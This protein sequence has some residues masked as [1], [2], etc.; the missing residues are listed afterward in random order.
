MAVFTGTSGNDVFTA[1]AGSNRYEGLAGT[2]KIIFNF[3]LTDATITFSGTEV[4]VDTAT[5][6]TVLTGFQTYQFSDG[7]VEENDGNPLV[8]DLFYY[9]QNHDVWL[10][11]ADADA[12]Y[13]NYGWKEGRNPNPFFDTD[14]YLAQ[15]AD[16]KA[17]GMNPLEHFHTYGWKDGRIPSLNFD[18]AGY[19]AQNP[20]VA[21]T[22]MD[23][24]AHFLAYGA[25]EGRQP[26][27]VGA[28][29][30]LSAP[31][32]PPAPA[33]A[34]VNNSVAANG[35][36]ADYYRA[37][38]PD[39][40][41][42]GID[43]FTHFQQ[44]GWKEG[45][46]PNA[47]FDVTGYLNTYLDIKAAGINPLEHYHSYG[48]K[49]GRN[50]SPGFDTS[51][52][53]DANL[54]V[55]N[56]GLD[57]LWHFLKFGSG[58]GRVA[59]PEDL[60]D[61]SA[62]D[63]HVDNGA[64]VNTPVGLTAS[65]GNWANAAY[66][67]TDSAGGRFK[68]DATTGVVSVANNS[69]ITMS[70]T[71]E[72]TVQALV[73]GHTTTK[74]F[75]IIVGT[76]SNGDPVITSDG[77]GAT[78]TKSI[79]ENTTAVTT[80]VA[81]DDGP[82]TTYS[83]AG[84]ADAAKFT[85]NASTGAL[86]FVSAPNF[87]SPT[88]ADTNNSYVVTVRASDGTFFDE[89]TITV[90]VTDANDIAPVFTSA[91]SANVAENSTSV[92]TLTAVD[93]DTVGTVTFSIVGGADAGK[94]TIVGN[95]LRFIDAPNFEA[96]TDAG[97]NNVYDV[98]I[99]ASDGVNVTLQSIAVTVTD[100]NEFAVTVIQDTDLAPDNVSEDAPTGT[101]VG[102]TAFA[103]D[104][105]SAN[106]VITYSLDDD[107]G[108]FAID[109]SSGVVTV[110]SPL[111]FEAAQSHTIVV[112]ATS[113]DGS[114][115]TRSYIIAVTNV[116]DNTP[117]AVADTNAAVE[118]VIKSV[119][120]NV[121][122]NDNDADGDA[123]SV[124]TTGT[125]DGT[126]GQLSLAAD[127][128]YTYKLWTDVAGASQAQLDAVQALASGSTELELFN[129]T[130]SDGSGPTSTST[131][132]ITVHGLNDAPTIA[133]GQS[134]T[135]AED[136][137]TVGA[138]VADDVDTGAVLT[139]GIVG[140]NDAGLFA[141]DPSTGQITVVGALD[142]ETATSHTLAVTV[143]DDQGATKGTFVTIN[144]T[145]VDDVAPTIGL[146][147]LSAAENQTAVAVL[148]ATDP[149]SA[150]TSNAS[151]HSY[152]FATGAGDNDNG[153]FALAPDGTLT[154]ASAQN[155]EAP[156]D[157]DHDGVYQVR[158]K[159]TDGAG[160]AREQSITVTLTD[161]NDA[162]TLSVGSP[163]PALET[164]S[165]TQAGIAVAAANAAITDPDNKIS[166]LEIDIS[167][168]YQSTG[169]N[170]EHAQP[171]ALGSFALS[172]FGGSA[173]F[174]DHG[175]HG[176][177]TVTFP[178]PITA[179]QATLVLQQI[180]YVNQ[181]GD[182]S[183]AIAQDDTR[184]IA[185]R[186]Q[187]EGGAW[188][189][190]ETH[191]V[192]VAA[193]VIDGNGAGTFVGGSFADTINGGGGNDT[194][195]GGKGNDVII[196]GADTD[197]V[198]YATE[199]TTSEVSVA[200]T[201]GVVVNLSD[202]A[203]DLDSLDPIYNS[204]ANNDPTIAANSATD[205]Y[206]D[207][208]TLSGI[209]NVIG[210]KFDDVFIN[211]T[212]PSVA[213]V[214]QGGGTS[215]SVEDASG[216]VAGDTVVYAGTL[217]EWGI[218][219]APGSS[220]DFTVTK[221]T[222][223]GAGT[224]DTLYNIEHIVIGNTIID[225]TKSVYVYNDG[226]LVNTYDSVEDAVTAANGMTPSGAGLVVEAGHNGATSYNE[227]EISVTQA[228]TIR[229]VGTARPTVEG[230]FTVSGTLDGEFNV[231]HLEIDA[232]GH[233][234][235]VFVSA[236][237]T[238]YA[239]SVTLE[240]VS[241]ANA[242]V[243]GFAYIREGNGST[244]T[245][246]DT[247]GAIS[248]IDSVFSGNAT[249]NVG[250]GG[251][252]DIMLFGYNQDLTIDN[253]EIGSPGAWAQKAIQMRGT[254]TGSDAAGVG[255]YALG[256]DVS[257]TD[258]KITGAYATDA[259]A[260]YR[261]ASFASFTGSGNEIAIT[262]PSNANDNAT[263][264][265]WA[266][267]NFDSV[268]GMIDLSGFFAAASNMAAPDGVTTPVPGWI[269]Q[270]QGLAGG[271]TFTGTDGRDLLV[272][273]GGTNTLIGGGGDDTYYVGANDTV[274]EGSNAGTD[275]VFTTDSYTLSANVENLTLLD[276]GVSRTEAF[277]NFDLG[278]IANGENGWTYAGTSDQT[279]VDLG[280][281]HGKVLRMSSDPSTGAFGGPY[282]PP[283]TAA[284]GEPQ[285][286]AKFSG[287]VIRFDFKAVDPNG[288][289]SRMEVDFGTANGTDRNSFM[290]IESTATG[291]IRIAV[292]EPTTTANNW[293]V[294]NFAAFTGNR[295]LATDADPAAWHQIEL[296]VTYADGPNNDL[297]DIYLDGQYI[298]TSTT[299]ENLRDWAGGTHAANAEA[300][301]TNQVFFRNSSGGAP[302][303]GPGGEN[304]GFYFDNIS[305]G[306]YNSIGGTGNDLDN[307]IT[308]NSG[309][310]VLT[311]GGGNDT[312]IGGAGVDT[313]K[314]D[315]AYSN[316]AVTFTANAHGF[317]TGA[318]H[319]QES[320][321]AGVVAE[322]TDTLSG[323]ERLAFNGLTL[324]L[325]KKV[326]LFDGSNKLV[327]T[328]DSIQAAVDGASDG[329]TIR[330]AAGSYEESVTIDQNIA[331]LG[332]NDGDSASGARG[333]E[334]VIRGQVTVS[335]AHSATDKVVI[336]GVKIYNTSDNTTS[337]TGITV[338]SAADVEIK[339]SI[340]Y[341][342][343]PNAN[344]APG[345]ADRAI[346]LD[347]GATGTILIEDNRFTGGPLAQ[348]MYGTAAWTSAIWSDGR[349]TAATVSSNTFEW[350][351]TAINADDFN[352]T[353][354]VSGNTF[355]NAGSGIS[356]GG[357]AGGANVDVASIT[358]IHDNTFSNVG[359]DFNLQ[360][361]SAAGKDVGLDL[362]A[363]NNHAVNPAT[364]AMTVLGGGN[365]DTIKGSAGIDIIT[366]NGGAD[367]IDGGAGDDTIAG[368]GG[369]DTL[370]GGAG[371][372]TLYG[373]A[374]AGADSGKDTATY[375]DARANY[376]V[377]VTTGTDG[378][379][380]AF[381][382]VTETTV[383]GTDEG[384]D[385]LS[386]IER[387]DFAGT[388]NDLD[389]TQGVQVF[390]AGV[391]IATAA[392]ITDA[393]AKADA[394]DTVLVNG[395]AGF[396]ALTNE[397]VTISE[398][399]TLQGVTGT[400]VTV[401][402]I[403]VNGGVSGANLVIDNIDVAG[404]AANY[405]VQIEE[406]SVYD[407]VTF[408]NGNVT[409]GSY[410]AFL[411]GD[412][413]ETGGPTGVL[414]VTIENANFT[415]NV[416]T[417]SGGGGDAAI[418]FYRYNGNVTLT[419]VDVT[420]SGAFIE[421][422]IQIR[423]NATLAASGT[424][425]FND[426]SVTGAFAKVG[427][428]IRDYLAT[429]LAFGGADPALNI[430][431]TGGT[432]YTGLHVDG[433]GGNV[434]LSVAPG[435]SVTNNSANPGR[436]DIQVDGLGDGSQITGDGGSDV[437][438]G[439]GGADT[440]NGLGGND[441]IDGG[442]G[443]DTIDAGAG[444]DLIVQTAGQGGGSIE[445]GS[446]TVADTVLVRGTTGS[447]TITVV[448]DGTKITTVDGTTL[449]GIEIVNGTLDA[450][451]VGGALPSVAGGSDTLSYTG[452]S[453][454]VAVNLAAGTA[455]GFAANPAI[456]AGTA[457][458]GFENVTG[459]AGDDHFIGDAGANTLDGGAGDDTLRG[460]A[461][462]D[463][464]IG[465]A[466]TLGDTAIYD[467][468]RGNYTVAA[469]T[470]DGFVTAF[471]D[472]TETVVTGTDEGHDTLSGIEILQ[473]NG[474]TLNL[475]QK[476]QLFDGGGQLIGTFDVIQDAVTAASDGNTIRIKGG[477][478]NEDITV[479]GKA[480]TIDGVET[481]GVNDVT[482]N[483]MITVTG[484]L[485]GAFAVT[486][487][488]I[489]AAGKNYG[490]NVTANST[491]GGS[492]T[493]DDVSISGAAVNGFAYVRAG[494]GTAPTLTDTVGA[495]TISNSAFSQ[496]G[497]TDNGTGDILLF[498]YNGALT[499]DTVVINSTT[500]GRAIQ[501]RGL[502]DGGDVAGV[503]PYDAAGALVL[504]D[505]TIS[506]TY[507]RDAIAFYNIANFVTSTV[508]NVNMT[509]TSAAWGLFNA[510][511][512]GGTLDLSGV[513]G[514]NLH[515]SG[516]E[517]N[518][519]GL[520]Q[521]DTL[522]GTA[523][524]DVI[525]GRGGAD[526][527][528]AGAGNDTIVWNGGVGND[529]IDGGT[530]A[531][532]DTL[533]IAS[534][535]SNITLD[536]DGTGNADEFTV[537]DGVGTATVKE[538][539]EV[540]VTLSS[541][542]TLTVTGDF[543]GTGVNTSTIT[544]TGAGGNE[545]VDASG[546]TGAGPGSPVGI[547]FTGGGGDDTFISGIGNDT[548][549]GGTGS[550]TAV[551]Q[552]AYSGN[553]T[554]DG[555]TATVT[556]ARGTD[557]YDGV[558]KIQFSGGKTV[559][560]VSQD[561]GSEYTE[562]AQLFDG[563]AANGEVAAGDVVLVAGGTYAGGFIVD[564]AD[565]TIKATEANVVIQSAS[566]VA[567]NAATMMQSGGY[568]GVFGNGITVKA[569]GITLDGI[570][571]SSYSHGIVM[572]APSGLDSV[573]NDL[574]LNGVTVED[575]WFGVFKDE[576]VGVEDLT[577]NGGLIAQGT[578]GVYFAGHDPAA[579]DATNVTIDGTH[580]ADIN[581]KGIYAETLQ[582]A[583]LFDH[584]DMDNV[585]Q[586]GRDGTW[587][588]PVSFANGNGAV[589]AG[590][591]I[592]LK[593]EAFTGSITIQNF[594]FDNVGS[595]TG[596]DPL[597]H[598]N[599]AAISIKV[600]DDGSYFAD[601]ASFTGP[602]VIQN[603]TID[604]TSTGIRVGEPVPDPALKADPDY[605]TGPSVTVTNV[606]INGERENARHDDIDNVTSAGILTYNGT[607]DADDIDVAP[608]SLSTVILNGLGGNDALSGGGGNDQLA[609]GADNDTLDG[610]AGIDT[611][612]YTQA[613]DASM[614]KT[615]GGGWQVAA[616]GAEGTDTLSDIEIVD[617]AGAGKFLLVG[618]GGYASI[619]AAYAAASDGDTI[620]LAG[621]SYAGN[622]T[623]EKAISIVGANYG[624]AADGTRGLESEITG[625]L[626][627][628]K[629]GVTIDGIKI[630][631]G[632][633]VGGT[634]A[635]IYVE[636]DNVTITNTVFVGDGTSGMAG[637]VTPYGADV[638][639]LTLSN[640]S[641]AGW[642]WATYFNP[643]TDFEV[644]GN[645]FHDT[646]LI[647]DDFADTSTIANNVFDGAGAGIGYG[648]FDSVDDLG[649]VADGTNTYSNGSNN[650]IYLYGDG[651]A[652]GQTVYGTQF[653]DYVTDQW[654]YV[655]NSGDDDYVVGRDGNDYFDMTAG[656]DTM[657]GGAG[658]DVAIGGAGTDKAV[659]TGAIAVSNISLVADADSVTAG[660]Q[661]G[662]Q[663]DAT[664]SG[665]GT[666]G[667]IDVEIVEYGGGAGRYL[668][669]GQGG[670]TT[671]QDAV[672]AANDGDTILI[673]PGTW[674][675][676]GNTNIT[677][678]KAVT[679]IGMGATRGD[680][681][682]DATGAA[683]GFTID[684]AADKDGKTVAFKN[685]TVDNAGNS[686]IQASDKQV[687]GTLSLDNVAITDSGYN[688]LYVAGR[689]AS[690]AYAQAG[691]QSVVIA[692][693][694]FANNAQTSNNAANIMFFE[695]DGNAALTNVA[696]TNNVAG[697]NS[698]AFG[699]QFNGS[700]SDLYDQAGFPGVGSYDVLTKMGTVSF[701][702]VSIS[703]NYRKPGLY[704]QGYTDTTGLTFTNSSVDVTSTSWL[705]PVLIDPMADQLP[706]GMPGTAANAGSFFNETGANGSYNLSGLSVVQ[707]VGQFNEL[708][709][710]TRADTIVGTDANDQ[711][712][713]FAGDDNLSGGGGD[714]VFI[715]AAS[716]DHGSAE[717]INGGTGTDTIR[718]TSVAPN[719][720]LV[721]SGLISNID[722]IEISN[723]AGANT[724]TTTLN[725]DASAAG[726][727]YT[728][729]GNDGANVLTAGMGVNVVNAGGGND[730]IVAINDGVADTYNG[731]SNDAVNALLGTGGDTIDYSSS[732]DGVT[733]ALVAGG[734]TLTDVQSGNDVLIGIENIIGGSGI[735]ILTGDSGANILRG[736]G[737]NDSIVGGGGSDRLV[738]GAGADKLSGGA[739]ADVFVYEQKADVGT[740][741]DGMQ[742]L[743]SGFSLAEGDVFGFT[744]SFFD[745]FGV[746]LPGDFFVGGHVNS[747]YFVNFNV[748]GTTY[749]GG[750]G[751]PVFILDDTTPGFAG[752]LWFDADGDNDLS[753]A[754]AVKIA[755]LS[756]SSVIA[757]LDHNNLLLV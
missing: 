266:V 640:S 307:I 627:V 405:A 497:G 93:S 520:A 64:A 542:N 516:P 475:A 287:Q 250:S 727:A 137:S 107:A 273:R 672:N 112:R 416:T 700:D 486:D 563:N 355:Q 272:G 332:A 651:D 389:L 371:N 496:N 539:E 209:E 18:P 752:T 601:P 538:I 596:T 462:D 180:E 40:V 713:G 498:G 196:G 616:G 227:G 595:S 248:I 611:A 753:D 215:A 7:T 667:L 207:T 607:A 481:G 359:T 149:D 694:L 22:H 397:D 289:N 711:I 349:Q 87:E 369:D 473:F 206:G 54:D 213:N 638:S 94:F 280:G 363:R 429:T 723:A 417:G 432:A 431:I 47:Y 377:A 126:Y 535:G 166:K 358:S 589:G 501:M 637:V 1:A 736:G 599:G 719:D 92:L 361:I 260:F 725:V 225:L 158:V 33:A 325:T 136:A 443:A 75:T 210:T 502:Q 108:H 590:I 645:H 492:V 602:I 606:T 167:G 271:E 519:T 480:I 186:V 368:S 24:L 249:A 414:S 274:T 484:T 373:G 119:T 228:M 444:D 521:G 197:T 390:R 269:A 600:R 300:N 660:S 6:H 240:D 17:L 639:G 452:T 341:S 528:K 756:N 513:T 261:I 141:I 744:Q 739:D 57:P 19:L 675:G 34:A 104:A 424:L 291:G 508:T 659:Y 479:N 625:Q 44:Y 404:A 233:D 353:F 26:V 128:S 264:E 560:L 329:Y 716:G 67:L 48:W 509:G 185:V 77:G 628:K 9:A 378:F 226:Y 343:V 154:F 70:A 55:K 176:T 574:T 612:V 474:T 577:I 252:G 460:G 441:F 656:D 193:D 356:I 314:Y 722:E 337:F 693:S 253:V 334:S 138:V 28:I 412:G 85:I 211:A 295:T 208:D 146:T 663:V 597:G 631:D 160:N 402:S 545:T 27:A 66:S 731:G 204:T 231:E 569:D 121:L 472:V 613:I 313:A 199:T 562:I 754:Q 465:G 487:L 277:G 531:G 151:N 527:I 342:P 407:S 42:A 741:T 455:T 505:L 282:S 62:A 598:V 317:V 428:A 555:T 145:D 653:D 415:G 310:N 309:D 218:K 60:L 191:D 470:V 360:N 709:G 131:L 335:A 685:L 463:T 302:N 687:L 53:L 139:Y 392:T 49:E 396:Y 708:D 346:M 559:W 195:T 275:Q 23:P 530:E 552:A 65:W 223:A 101:V 200:G 189:N 733:I 109:G 110:S 257:I 561:A 245:L 198:D 621:G 556:G 566:P 278:P 467:D 655:A 728:L 220:D 379:V 580:F 118:D 393:L 175:T 699:I 458:S 292:N 347:T 21:A 41:A 202:S 454:G 755:D 490:V 265:P 447:D 130:I 394:G 59:H 3:A 25:D 649:A 591:D 642:Y 735:D 721:L 522:T 232:T 740:A 367:S 182:F 156:G 419:N 285:T 571:V 512:V 376:T 142:Y 676:A 370:H 534:N 691:V 243:N 164:A 333:A 710:T 408:K 184:T 172:L 320:G 80:V 581:E 76:G 558:G 511:G 615:N 115:Q 187:D 592:N 383:T 350:V 242:R 36:D 348:N 671:I 102:I 123:L 717:A 695:F 526:T 515:A 652:G 134:F 296:R 31:L 673:A 584:L 410:T 375:D 677:V 742:D 459:G 594:D 230:R 236:G 388:A 633:D 648:V 445:G 304:E 610:N 456:G 409:G 750:T 618:N 324:D 279:I 576:F 543:D 488:N 398:G 133:A 686:G 634:K 635:G 698:A 374:L 177:L 658:D 37:H 234:Y 170:A 168:G 401:G 35:F 603:G 56:A 97:G 624:I 450:S 311:G 192:N 15:Y 221:L 2:D 194:L 670:F 90:N 387:L 732:T 20:D 148:A 749:A 181:I 629:D 684:M 550:D 155:F 29:P 319:V 45:R 690:G 471:T 704:V 413:D 173:S 654:K 254:Q 113:Q 418:T 451:A 339:N 74:S 546:M 557:T 532:A 743:I 214:F 636:G 229:G 281:S 425:T 439:Y 106:N 730:R 674:T 122:A 286:T 105:D 697:A 386:G 643:S 720:T 96:P 461:G 327:G 403:K 219:L 626:Y 338:G 316:Y 579:L 270:M 724:G 696:V 604:G 583:T 485:N 63:E 51:K 666:D 585:G 61:K 13:A 438:L 582:G 541:G 294:N 120:G 14:F 326:Q 303:D 586:F 668:L 263:L 553:V 276:N 679:F 707:K 190:V 241:I 259:I 453:V 205:T 446:H 568:P 212:N 587:A 46:D 529:S 144:V 163:L 623:I 476:V 524:D 482:L 284:A 78:A 293:A 630:K 255:P 400:T 157:A 216:E 570:K 365:A 345:T 318:T 617:G 507:N 203:Y 547:V 399:I 52:Y 726:G 678:D 312:L 575:F 494:N 256:G 95:Q 706:S 567:G 125:F 738:G 299:F 140:G 554:W 510:D 701:D 315:D 244:P 161:A 12:H 116:D 665:E 298:G 69:L 422:G 290:A 647:G 692:G 117:S 689:K 757:G 5:S 477:T 500:G 268:G 4:I 514:T 745:D 331:I 430:N 751:Q 135:V 620:V 129:Y 143:T 427:V 395:G 536:A 746:I 525:A 641:F 323:I 448:Y 572:A 605:T 468:A 165:S 491:G 222:G 357:S 8:S 680:T 406:A 258:L 499:I 89:Q 489:N 159:V 162:P 588:Q 434:D 669:V 523:N 308:G 88:D 132:T 544:V 124:T 549:H 681:V 517:A 362:T 43:P 82:S 440:I 466:H 251:R 718:F 449:S 644:T 382:S 737:A 609:G 98:Q 518:V 301:Q 99:Q 646:G 703:G 411:V 715:I 111:D 391:L 351:R 178:T 32:A 100:A 58:E 420:G 548:F 423:G 657:V 91:S 344:N 10:A 224:V 330:L 457:I 297:I 352:S 437:L 578:Y 39:V 729:T 381:T 79:S 385:T 493:L 127:G 540:K 664:A 239:G 336:D 262:R 372:D 354:T 84:G 30:V 433:V 702:T 114:F 747:N 147:A 235:A 188:S 712:T 174:A 38:N 171:N 152:A 573:V 247:V 650:G 593:R 169:T 734:A 322:G 506:G 483:G 682:I 537:S 380:T 435:V 495:V 72:I 83:I 688:G 564:K 426:V 81:A 478:Y 533:Q 464:L 305:Y 384:T 504:K 11:K 179:A 103:N 608:T 421:N 442:A 366:G 614:I 306:V 217:G 619:A 86:S 246:T 632:A 364:D 551:Y 288:D 150:S 565:V 73:D 267:I 340:F 237:S 661:A 469:T 283:L 683:N 183:L 622:F 321:P 714:D 68:I 748:T 328:F 436:R 153:L 238:G 662:W 503:G 50:P 201:H 705:K 16:V 71:H